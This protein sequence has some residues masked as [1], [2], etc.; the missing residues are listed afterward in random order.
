MKELINIGNSVDDGTGDYMRV[1][2]DKINNNFNELYTELGD[3]TNPFPAGSWEEIDSVT[4]QILDAKFGKSYSINTT[5]GQ[6]QVNLPKGSIKDYNKPVKIRDVYSTWSTNPVTLVPATGDTIKGA[7]SST[8]ISTNL[9]DLELVYCAPGR[10]EYV[11]N[12]QLNRIS[13]GDV[14]TISRREFIAT[15]GQQ[16]FL[17]VFNGNEYNAANIQIY[18]RG[19]MLFYGTDFSVDSDFGSPGIG[20]DIVQLDGRNIRLREPCEAGDA[21][22]IITFLDGIAQWRSTYNRLDLVLLEKTE[23][24][25]QTIPGVCLVEDLSTIDTIT[26]EQFGYKLTSNS[27]LV[28]QNTFEVYLNGIFLNENGTT[29]IPLFECDGAYANNQEDCELQFGTWKANYD[30][31]T[32]ILDEDETVIAIQFSRPFTH[33]DTISIKWFNNNIGTTLELE[34]ILI[35]T[36]KNYVQRGQP[37]NLTGTV[38]ITDYDNPSW[39]NVEE[40]G[41]TTVDTGNISG[42]FDV[43]YPVGTVYENFVNPNNPSTYMYFGSWILAG[44]RQM[45]VGWTN[46]QTDTLFGLNNN[47]IDVNGNPSAT[48]G[49]T[50]GHREL[51]LTN[52]Q[53]P[54]ST[55][56]EE[57]LIVDDNGTIIVGG[58]QFD[59]DEQGPAY[60]KYREAKVNINP[61][62]TPPKNLDILSPYITVYRWMRIA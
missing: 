23:T 36:D 33:N 54:A 58:C 2:G 25:E 60:D 13:T 11:A 6:V 12:K 62:H 38:R 40:N 43:I 19:N 46:D 17:D 47:D 57:T 55:S 27:G 14:S 7:S 59:P 32:V 56:T 52:D 22:I 20:T 16:D 4:N 28:N 42:I 3:G 9:S 44:T 34:D 37:L 26:L 21:V 41:P 50:G 35:E 10:W 39:P 53:I 61:T 24:N 30:D 31:Y 45:L 15:E 1:G 51:T 8:E 48:A 18:R 29:G 5:A 49:G